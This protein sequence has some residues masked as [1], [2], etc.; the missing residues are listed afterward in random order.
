[1]PKSKVVYKRNR[2]SVI[3]NDKS[4]NIYV[5]IMSRANIVRRKSLKS[6]TM[7]Q[8]KESNSNVNSPVQRT[9]SLLV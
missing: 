4:E 6:T 1:M 7:A 2:D 5:E 3:L 8:T 9:S